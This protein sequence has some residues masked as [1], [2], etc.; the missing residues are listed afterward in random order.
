MKTRQV[1]VKVFDKN[2]TRTDRVGLVFCFH[3]FPSGEIHLFIIVI[4]HSESFIMSHI[5][6]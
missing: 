3:Y 1:P 6:V 5:F 4:S 2:E